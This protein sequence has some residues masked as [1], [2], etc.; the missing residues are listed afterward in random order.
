MIVIALHACTPKNLIGAARSNNLEAVKY[1]LEYGPD[2]LN[3]NA[4]ESDKVSVIECVYVYAFILCM[5]G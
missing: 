2:D 3:V 1:I 4:T 5:H